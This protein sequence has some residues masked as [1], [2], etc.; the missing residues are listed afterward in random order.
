MNNNHK[1]KVMK[2]AC[3]L[4]LLL[5]LSRGASAIIPENGW[6]WASNE[7]GRGFNI[8]VQN[9][10][11][12]FAS[13]AYESNGAPAW[14]VAGGPMTSDRDF[15]ASLTKFSGGQCF[16][17]PYSAPVQVAAGTVTLRFTSSQTAVLAING[18]SIN[19]KRF[20]FWA[21]EA[22]PDAMLGEWS[23]VIGSAASPLY[24]GERIQYR[25]KFSDSTGVYLSG[26]RVGSAGNTA[27]L[28]YNAARGL[29]TALLDSSTTFYRY[30]EFSQ[31]GFNRVEGN[32]WLVTKG[33]QVSGAGTFFQG[34]RT[35]SFA[36][37]T[38]GTGPASTKSASADARRQ[39]RDEALHNAIALDMK[40]AVSAAAS[41]ASSEDF[42]ALERILEHSRGAPSAQ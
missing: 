24:D 29:W 7:S 30:F 32:F 23:S 19:V 10:V 39:Q 18:T 38:S 16:G 9:N 42:L 35:A 36:W 1:G 25:S 6:W 3:A 20:D 21:N 12:F 13:F 31:T 34:F 14:L 26:A 8:E 41:P 40:D 15:T 11:I 5:L 22:T 27:V 37:V 17:C 2:R 28:G 33:T 4:L